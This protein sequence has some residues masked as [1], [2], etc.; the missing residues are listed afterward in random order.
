MQ[1]IIVLL[2]WFFSF[3]PV[4]CGIGLIVFTVLNKDPIAHRVLASFSFTFFVQTIFTI[5]LIKFRKM[6]K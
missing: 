5:L 2:K 3:V 6:L 4:A 1:Q